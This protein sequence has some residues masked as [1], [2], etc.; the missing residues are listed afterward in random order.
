MKQLLSFKP[1]FN[2]TAK[3]LD[4]SAY[5]GFSIN[6]L[7]G[8]INVTQG[9]PI[10]AP[11]TPTIGTTSINGSVITLQYDTSAHS[12]SDVLNIYYDTAAGYESNTPLERG[13]QLQMMQE[14]MDQ[15]L[16][17]LK[18]MNL[19]LAQGLNINFDDVQ[20]IRNDINNPTNQPSTF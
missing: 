1:V 19:I 5:P 9:T 3:T 15:T 14:T 12:A 18:V 11:G 20:A 8:V 16:V 10:Y 17:E 4:F 7:F 13:G 6:K 2:P